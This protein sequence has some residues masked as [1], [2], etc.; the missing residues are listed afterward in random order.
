MQISSNI[1]IPIP[2]RV[3]AI[4]QLCI[5][6]TMILSNMGYPFMGEL[7]ANRS[8]QLIFDTVIGV[9]SEKVAAASDS[10]RALQY[11]RY[12]QRNAAR[13]SQLS[14]A[15]KSYILEQYD[16]LQAKNRAS[17]FSKLKRSIHILI[18]EISP[19]EQ[20]WLLLSIV[21]C[22]LIL[23]RVEGAVQ[24]IWLLPLLASVYAIDNRLHGADVGMTHE[25][26]LFPSEQVIIENYLNEP[27][28]GGI[29][30]QE[31]QL[32]KGWQLYLVREWAKVEPS[33]TVNIFEE[34]VE[35]GEFAFDLA[36]L[37]AQIKDRNVEASPFRRKESVSLLAL[38]LLWNLFL[39][40]FVNV[41][42]FDEPRREVLR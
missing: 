38:Y 12:Q 36:R 6:F 19:W 22:I 29:T 1:F 7:F 27:L 39:A 14:E 26:S 10:P 42:S 17:F 20:A 5:A 11:N 2:A 31:E 8:A 37:D 3:V 4:L 9:N 23:M 16:A 30:E 15:Q 28:S 41:N 21:V 24:A 40:G 18:F 32:R 33:Q 25:A 34:Q 35:I 13:F